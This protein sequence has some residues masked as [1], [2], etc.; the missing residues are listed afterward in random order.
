LTFKG[1][2]ELVALPLKEGMEVARDK[3]M[4]KSFYWNTGGPH[5]RNG[6]HTG[7]IPVIPSCQATLTHMWPI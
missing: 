2:T 7:T 6:K 5:L 1:L 3:N 4:Q